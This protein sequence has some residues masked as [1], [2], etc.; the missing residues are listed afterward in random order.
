MNE[1]LKKLGKLLNNYNATI[2]AE[3]C[4]NEV[5]LIVTVNGEVADIFTNTLNAEYCK[6]IADSA[7][8]C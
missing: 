4:G 1:F 8:S 5:M 6:N 3:D 2:I 7:K